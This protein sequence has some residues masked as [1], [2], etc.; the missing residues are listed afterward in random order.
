MFQVTK[1]GIY[2][3]NKMMYELLIEMKLSNRGGGRM[4]P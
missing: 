4:L 3:D 2:C 1:Y